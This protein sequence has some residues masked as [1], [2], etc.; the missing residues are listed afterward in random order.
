MTVHTSTRMQSDAGGLQTRT[1]IPSQN[2]FLSIMQARKLAKLDGLA[3]LVGLASQSGLGWR[4]S[5]QT[6]SKLK[7]DEL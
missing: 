3:G 6:N 2:S 4:I 1:S 7:M 5:K